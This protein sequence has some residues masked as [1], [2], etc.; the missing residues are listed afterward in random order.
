MSV[1]YFQNM[2]IWKKWLLHEKL[3]ELL[4]PINWFLGET[5]FAGK[6]VS[7]GGLSGKLVWRGNWFFVTLGKTFINI[8]VVKQSTYNAKV[9]DNEILWLFKKLSRW[10]KIAKKKATI[11]M[12]QGKL[13]M[14][15]PTWVNPNT[16]KKQSCLLVH[17]FHFNLAELIFLKQIFT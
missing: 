9:S 17:S 6:L 4:H 12:G 3:K 5:G 15:Y 16:E 11:K 13:R 7:W 14:K 8:L 1:T 10:Q 2:V